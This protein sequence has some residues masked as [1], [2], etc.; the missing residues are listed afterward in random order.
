VFNPPN[1]GVGP[2]V[3][4]YTAL[5]TGEGFHVKRRPR[6]PSQERFTRECRELLLSEQESVL[7]ALFCPECDLG[8]QAELSIALCGWTVR[9]FLE[10]VEGRSGKPSQA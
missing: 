8:A 7:H 3:E 9:E 4:R 1:T 10:V 2:F 6:H 5:P